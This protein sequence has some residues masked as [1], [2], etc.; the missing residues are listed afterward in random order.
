M[1]KKVKCYFGTLL[2]ALASG[3]SAIQA[4]EVKDNQTSVRQKLETHYSEQLSKLRTE[5]ILA[6]P[7]ESVQKVSDYQDYCRIEKALRSDFENA[8][9]D[10]SK[11]AT[12]QALVDHAKNKWI[13]GAQKDIENAKAILKKAT[14]EAA[15]KAAN[16]LLEKC[17]ANKKA[18]IDALKERQSI[19]NKA[20]DEEP[21]LLKNVEV[22]QNK[23]LKACANTLSSLGQIGKGTF[24]ASDKLS[25]FVKACKVEKQLELELNTVKTDLGK[26]KK[27]RGAVGHAKNKWIGDAEKGITKTQTILKNAKTEDERKAALQELE[28]WHENK[29]AGVEA[30]KKHESILNELL[31][32]EPALNTKIEAGTVRF[33]KAK[34]TSQLTLRQLSLNTVLNSDTLDK[35]LMKFILLNEAKPSGLAEYASQGNEQQ[36]LVARLLADTNLIKQMLMA[37]G[38]NNG[39]YGQAMEIYT[40]IL[41]TSKKSKNGILQRLALAVSLEHAQPIKQRNASALKDAPLT[42]D[43]LKRYLSYEK[44]YLADELDS[45]FKDLNIWELRM[46]ISGSEPDEISAWGRKMLRNY[47][48]DHI[49]NPDYRWRYVGAV[50]TEIKY[51]SGY[52]KEDKPE[53]QF[54]QNILMNGGICGRRAFFGRFILRSF[55]IPTTARPQPGHAALAHWTDEGWVLCLGA[56]WGAGWTK[57]RYKKDL[58]FLATTQAREDMDAYIMVK[59][60]QWLGDVFNEERVFGLHSGTPGFWYGVSLY[61]QR[62]ILDKINAKTLAAVG[63][64]LGEAN[65]SK[66][67]YDLVK[68]D[69]TDADRKIITHRRR[70][71]ITIPA[72]ACSK[73]RESTSKI[74]FMPSN[75][76]GKQ[77]HYSR[78]GAAENFEYTIDVPNAGK[79]HLTARVVT[80]TPRQNLNLRINDAK[81]SATMELPFTAGMW[82]STEA[83][84]ITLSEGQNILQFSRS[85]NDIRGL[86]IKDFSLMPSR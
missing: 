11:V 10:F 56:G 48:P 2:V 41:E 76:G 78:V 34:R 50:R 33:A 21:A 16:E 66:V 20:Q 42:V 47:R 51:R 37:D 70:G 43:P 32:E 27:A 52:G 74:I 64:E 49:T 83:I 80:P 67:K 31:K 84:E 25:A 38:A 4:V 63:E 29:K 23:W 45:A 86:T 81:E 40:Q 24:L 3:L 46:V 85:G 19:L 62:G 6:L 36:K 65:E 71:N 1:N 68:T 79:Y 35:K 13:G 8:K 26:I 17:Q 72:V 14:T 75:L 69:I 77:L 18:G 60:A 73:P 82:G 15:R 30:L 55:G 57:T 58:D 53:Y 7:I 5:I 9:K 12:A 28:K 22:L 44:A 54:Y 61:T 59:R 39:L